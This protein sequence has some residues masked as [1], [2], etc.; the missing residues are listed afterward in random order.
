MGGRL[1]TTY[2][3]ACNRPHTRRIFSGIGFRAWNPPASKP[4]LY[5]L[6]TTDSVNNLSLHQKFKDITDHLA[7]CRCRN[8]Y[9]YL[10]LVGISRNLLLDTLVI[11]DEGAIS[12]ITYAH[13]RS[14]KP[15][16][17]I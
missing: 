6:A 10:I 13:T 17:T 5:Y 3:L 9:D 15:L 7:R 14:S 8:T 4:R 1:A 11:N 16:L 12:T 2:D